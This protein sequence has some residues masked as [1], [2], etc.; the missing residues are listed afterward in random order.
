MSKYQ[1]HESF[2][3]A[4]HVTHGCGHRYDAAECAAAIAAS[5]IFDLLG[6]KRVDVRGVDLLELPAAIRYILVDADDGEEY[7]DLASIDDV[8][9]R[10]AAGIDAALHADGV[11]VATIGSAYVRAI[12]TEG[13]V[14][15]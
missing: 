1:V 9:A 11:F 2:N 12:D 15:A 13:E 5:A 8:R 10:L 14:E 7:I 6:W 4:A 3:D